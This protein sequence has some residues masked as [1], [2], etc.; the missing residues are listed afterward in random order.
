MIF[1][2]TI[3]ALSTPPGIGGIGVIRVSGNEAIDIVDKVFKKAG[4]NTTLKELP[5]HTIHYGH[6]KNSKNETIDEVLVMLMKAPKT[7]TKE[8]VVE[9]NCHGGPVPIEAVLMEL[10]KNGARLAEKGEFTKRAFLNG[11]IDLA[12]VEAVM[13]IIEA[14]TTTSLAQAVNQLEGSL[15]KKIKGYQD[16][17][18]QMIARIEVSIDYPEYDMDEPI[19]DLF[20]EEVK[21]LN[22]QL[23]ELL[24]TA[25]TGKMIRDGVKTAIVGQPNVGKSSLLNTLLEENKAIVTDIPG[26]T[27]DIV[28]AYFSVEGIPFLL[29]DTAGIRET[30]DTVEKIGVERSRASIEEADLIVMV[31]DYSR[32]LEETE[33]QM[34]NYLKGKKVLYVLNKVDLKVERSNSIT[35]EIMKEYVGKDGLILSISTKSKEGIEALK[36]AMKSLVLT[37]DVV[38]E[39]QAII[40]NRRQKEALIKAVGSLD[41]VESS[42]E[43]GMPEDCLA[44]D[45]HDAYG[46]LGMVIGESLKEEIINELFT[47]FCLGK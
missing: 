4:K 6:I 46:H 33:V 47:R 43:M 41:K 8:D 3:A 5:S 40:S 21:V 2:D 30:D 17:L 20:E 38:V 22:H 44:I 13:D 18:I 19:T 10:I 12:Q 26:T 27:R 32:P 37:G 16:A 9:I 31:L 23:K 45:L 15:S 7:F 28:E 24:K 11:R 42:I 36:K 35:Q 1:E 29:L 25:D 14:K 39:K 34:I